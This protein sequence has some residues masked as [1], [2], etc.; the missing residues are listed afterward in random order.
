MSAVATRSGVSKATLYNHFR[1]KDD[2]LR[3]LVLREVELLAD[4]ADAADGPGESR[5][6]RPGG[7]AG[8]RARAGRRHRG[9]ARGRPPGG[10]RGPRRARSPAG[11]RRQPRLGHRAGAAVGAARAAARRPAGP[12]RSRLGR[13]PGAGPRGPGRCRWSPRQRWP[14]QQLRPGAACATRQRRSPR[15][16]PVPA[17][18]LAPVRDR[19]DSSGTS[20]STASWG[21]GPCSARRIGVPQRRHGC[22]P[23]RYTQ[24]S[25]AAAGCRR[26]SSART[27]RD[28]RAHQPPRPLDQSAEVG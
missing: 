25:C 27:V 4:D 13:G 12:P 6:R 26:S 23:R 8:G 17:R 19:A 20:R 16:S 2:V 18:S 11:G 5:R 21:A 28:V 7:R 24:C 15:R 10:R 22:P 9:R 14:G 3:A 1:T